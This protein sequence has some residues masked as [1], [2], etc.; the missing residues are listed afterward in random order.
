MKATFD[1]LE[2][3]IVELGVDVDPVFTQQNLQIVGHVLPAQVD[4]LHRV[5]QFVPVV[6]WHH[7]RDALATFD[8]EPI[9]LAEGVQRQDSLSPEENRREV[10]VFEQ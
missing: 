6:N 7:L 9:L 10:V 3:Q 4:L 5:V 2:N 1:V 8:H